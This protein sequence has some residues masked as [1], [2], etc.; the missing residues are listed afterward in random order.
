MDAV[1]VGGGVGGVDVLGDVTADVVTFCVQ[2][3]SESCLKSSLALALSLSIIL[4]SPSSSEST[5]WRL[6][7]VWAVLLVEMVEGAGSDVL[8][9]VVFAEGL[10]VMAAEVGVGSAG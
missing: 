4:I 8:A 3:S 2:S 10:A 9:E 5:V 7:A 1:E 6:L